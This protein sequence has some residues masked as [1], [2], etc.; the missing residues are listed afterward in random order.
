MCVESRQQHILCICTK[1]QIVTKQMGKIHWNEQVS[2]VHT[3]NVSLKLNGN[4]H[5]WDQILPSVADELRLEVCSV[6]TG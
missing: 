4:P 3:E 2:F 1:T 6:H 5:E